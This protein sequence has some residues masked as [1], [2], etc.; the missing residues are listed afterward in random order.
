MFGKITIQKYLDPATPV[1]HVHINNIV[2]LN[3]VID[4]WVSINFMTKDT[5]LKLNLQG[6][7][8]KITIVLHLVGFNLVQKLPTY[9]F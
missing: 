8:R 6:A 4:L 5:I 3:S 2:V 9:E 1:I 7:L